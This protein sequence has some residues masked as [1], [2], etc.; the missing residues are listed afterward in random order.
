MHPFNEN[1][2]NSV[3]TKGGRGM[4]Q[5]IHSMLNKVTNCGIQVDF[6][7]VEMFNPENSKTKSNFNKNSSVS[8]DIKF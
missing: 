4:Y 6:N 3:D 8:G 5:T 7:N 1:E 2:S